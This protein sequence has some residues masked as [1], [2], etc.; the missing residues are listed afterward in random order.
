MR[1]L[2]LP[3]LLCS[4]HYDGPPEVA[5]V[6]PEGGTFVPGDP[7]RLTFSEP[8]DPSSLVLRLWPSARDGEGRLQPGLTP[9]LQDCTVADCGGATLVVDGDTLGATLALA[10]GALDRPDVPMILEVAEGLADAGGTRTGAPR[11]FDLQFR[12]HRLVN[13]A[14]VPFDQG[15]YLIVAELQEPIP[16][17]ITLMSDVR[18]AEGGTMALAGAEADEF[19]GAPKNTRDPTHLAIDVTPYGFAMFATGFV[20]FDDGERFLETDPVPIELDLGALS[21]AIEDV[22]LNAKIVKD[23]ATGRDRLDG[24]L[25]YSRTILNPG[26]DGFAYPAGHAAFLADLVPEAQIPE[27]T[28]ALCGALCGGVIGACEP[29]QDFPPAVLCE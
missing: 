5:L 7:L 6:A 11:W 24:I 18:V 8:I 3:L 15:V 17:V 27:G 28:P 9:K 25:S 21:V 13:T 10:G 20:T 14:P 23:P 16:T 4:C 1:R 2:L 26:P 19:G 22:R 29:P 12:H